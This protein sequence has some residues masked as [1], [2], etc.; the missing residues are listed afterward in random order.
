LIGALVGHGEEAR[1]GIWRPFFYPE[2]ETP[3][4]N[5][6][7]AGAPALGENWIVPRLGMEF[8]W[9]ASL[10]AWVGKYEVT[11]Q[12]YRSFKPRY[13]S[14][15]FN[16]HSLNDDRQPVV[17]VNHADAVAY[18]EWLTH[19]EG[20]A[21]RLPDGYRYRLP[22]AQEWTALAQCGDRREY[23]WGSAMPPT[24][25]NYHGQEG[26]G[27]LPKIN[28]Y[29]DGFPV[30]CPVEK[31][32]ENEWGLYGVGGNVWEITIKSAK[33][34]TFDAWR[35]GSWGNHHP[36]HLNSLCTYNFDAACRRPD[37]GFRLVLS[38][39]QSRPTPAGR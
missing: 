28:G 25:G 32:G 4:V 8:V 9:V 16:L 20:R 39:G 35:G 6:E 34:M 21:G 30:T 31:S 13:A 7:E 18:A 2:E 38:H 33:D 24:Y 10:N 29:N 15:N 22:T 1:A 5:R 14:P 36:Y 12:E 26:A 37:V 27:P 17:F 23:P 11:N 19:R 3:V